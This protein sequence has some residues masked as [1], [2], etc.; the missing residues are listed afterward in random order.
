M[1]GLVLASNG[2]LYGTTTDGG[3]DYG[4]VFEVTP[5]GTFTTVYNVC[6]QGG[7]QDAG[8]PYGGLVQD[9]NGEFYGTTPYGGFRKICKGGCGTV[10]S[11]S[12]GLGPF[13]ETQ[14]TSGKVGSA[15]KILG[16]GLTGASSVTFNGTAAVFTVSPSGAAISTTV[17]AGATSGPVQVVTPNGTLSSNVPFRVL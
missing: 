5:S 12:V 14:T 4:T 8:A 2:D 17:P 16:T 3:A 15:V 10:F 11:L 1:A 9:T 13:V 7:C 6:P